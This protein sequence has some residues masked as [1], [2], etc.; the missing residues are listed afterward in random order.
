[1][2]RC[3]I[4]SHDAGGA[5]IVSSWARMTGGAEYFCVAGPAL[6]IFSAKIPGFVNQ[7]IELID[8]ILSKVDEVLTGTSGK[9]DF[10]RIIHRKAKALGIKTIA[11]LDHWVNYEMRFQL[12]GS[13]VLPDEIWVGDKYAY[14]IAEKIFPKEMLKLFENPYLAEIAQKVA[15][16][17]SMKVADAQKIKVLYVCE[18]IFSHYGYNEFL[19]LEQYLQYL[20]QNEKNHFEIRVRLH[21]SEPTSKYNALIA[22]YIQNFD[23]YESKVADIISDCQWADWVV[24]CETMAMVIALKLDKKVFSNIPKG[25][26]PCSLP[27]PNIVNLF[28]VEK[29]S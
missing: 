28:N 26:K 18:P 1:M 11:F 15:A 8:E 3:L 13:I 4:A 5:E 2:K 27:F 6:K 10:E 20:M 24:G 7:P 9:N 22:N 14:E 12:N 21:P 16:L 19:A 25:G 29:L 23:I 17:D